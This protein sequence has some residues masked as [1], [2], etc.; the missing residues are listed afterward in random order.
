LL[1][2]G[3][4]TIDLDENEKVKLTFE[5]SVGAPVAPSTL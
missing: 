2:G 1:H 3:R 5:D 4:V